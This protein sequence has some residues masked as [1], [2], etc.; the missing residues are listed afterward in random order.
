MYSIFSKFLCVYN[1]DIGNGR[2]YLNYGMSTSPGM[3]RREPKLRFHMYTFSGNM[4]TFYDIMYD[5][6]I[7]KM[8]IERKIYLKSNETRVYSCE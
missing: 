1:L 2:L 7:K 3:P 5:F 4:Y 6:L 8:Y